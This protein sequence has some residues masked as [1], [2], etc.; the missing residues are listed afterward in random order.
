M[1]V[2]IEEVSA[3]LDIEPRSEP[4]QEEVAAQAP[5]KQVRQDA[6]RRYLRQLTRRQMRL[7]AN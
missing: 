7:K 4:G 5:P 1:P 6:L 3:E 2:I